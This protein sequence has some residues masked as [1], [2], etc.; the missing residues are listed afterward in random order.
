[1]IDVHT[2]DRELRFLA[3]IARA[4]NGCW[5]WIASCKPN[6]YGYFRRWKERGGG[7]AHR[8]AYEHFVGPI[9]DGLH[10]DHLCRNK[11]CVNP[12]HLEP[13]TQ[14]ENNRRQVV[15]LGAR[16]SACKRGHD[17]DRRYTSPNG[18]ITYCRECRNQRERA[19]RA[20]RSD[21]RV[22]Y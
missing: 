4:E 12:S 10:L 1:M 14:A 19:D 20:C 9:P 7:Y 13:V 22:A 8:W 5:E 11:R 21:G 15:A 2:H 16:S 3:K 17:L 6:G 18:K